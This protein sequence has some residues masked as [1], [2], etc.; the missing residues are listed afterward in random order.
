MKHTNDPPGTATNQIEQVRDRFERWRRDHPG[1]QRIPEELWVA[2]VKLAQQVGVNRTA[3]MLRL[4]Y[5]SLKQHMP[6]DSAVGANCQR[7]PQ[8]VEV[9]PLSSA[10]MPEC[11]VEL[12]NERGAKIRIQLRGAAMGEL[13]NLTRLFW[14]EL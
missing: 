14:R 9:L 7:A 3:K 11:C 1:R 6:A 8:F 2:A 4:G 5:E 13:S 10:T 12:E